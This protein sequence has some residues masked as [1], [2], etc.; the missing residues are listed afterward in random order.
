M[1]ALL[2]SKAQMNYFITIKDRYFWT[3]KSQIRINLFYENGKKIWY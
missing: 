1:E 2:K 3:N